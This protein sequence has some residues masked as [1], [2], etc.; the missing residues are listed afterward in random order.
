MEF[1]DDQDD[2]WNLSAEELDSLERDAFQKLAQQRI[3]S[4]S[5]C[6]SSSSYSYNHQQS[7]TTTNN[8]RNA[9]ETSIPNSL[10]NQVAPLS[11]GVRL[12]PTSSVDVKINP[13]NLDP[14][15]HRA[16]A[17]VSAVPDIRGNIVIMCCQYTGAPSSLIR[18]Q[19][20]P[21]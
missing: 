10:S 16:F 2:D 8:N 3:N 20:V 14:L 6:S 21:I 5:T 11:P 15:V 18:G 19:F 7:L 13:E 1:A 17:A 12:L 9:F 4:A